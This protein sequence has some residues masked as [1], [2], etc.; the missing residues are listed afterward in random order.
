MQL[1]MQPRSMQPSF[2]HS[3]THLTCHWT[4]QKCSGVTVT[5]VIAC[6]DVI[7]F[8]ACFGVMRRLGYIIICRTHQIDWTY[9]R[10]AQ[11]GFAGALG[12][13]SQFATLQLRA[14]MQDN[15]CVLMWVSPFTAH[16]TI[17]TLYNLLLCCRR[18]TT[19]LCLARVLT[20]E[21]QNARRLCQPQK[22]SF[23]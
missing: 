16:V 8:T 21:G 10:I 9:T 23:M 22:G 13:A 14:R 11:M 7:C 6:F 15:E 5:Y 18:Q 3:P 2:M 19:Y 1:L 4:F 20:T 17:P 12:I